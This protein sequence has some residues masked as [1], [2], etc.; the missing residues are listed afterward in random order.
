MLMATAI[1]A[2]TKSFSSGNCVVSADGSFRLGG[3]KAGKVTIR[4]FA[5]GAQR[6]ALLR[7][8][9]NGVELQNALEIQPNEEIAGLRVVLAP[10]TCMIRGRVTIQ[11]GTLPPG[12][13]LSA[14]ARS[15]NTDPSPVFGSEFVD[16]SSNGTFVIEN[17]GPGSYQVEVSAAVPAAGGVRSVSAKQTVVVTSARPAEVDLVL[18]LSG[19]APDK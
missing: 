2:Q 18:D 19:K 1:D 8:E 15:V 17:L 12:A 16:V 10:A 13:N 11:G 5:M 4:P 9:R 7:I 3:L 14:R 6:T